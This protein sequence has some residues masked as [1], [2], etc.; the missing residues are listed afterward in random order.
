M[1]HAHTQAHT[2]SNTHARTHACTHTHARARAFQGG[3]ARHAA[4]QGNLL[5]SLA[6]VGLV[7]ASG[8][9]ASPAVPSHAT[10]L[11]VAAAKTGLSFKAAFA[12]G[13][14]CNW[15]VCLGLWQAAAAQSI[16]GKAA[17]I[18]FPISAF[19]AM[20]FDHSVANMFLLPM[21]SPASHTRLTV[22]PIG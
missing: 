7:V 11:A 22:T 14:L 2:P 17:A 19:V 6:L 12:R 20:G 18:W 16:G 13:V 1:M 4:P 8:V 10:A 5:G 21:V 9:F 15:L 3:D